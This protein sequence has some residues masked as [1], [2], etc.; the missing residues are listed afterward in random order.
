V[1]EVAGGP[2]TKKR[3]EAELAELRASQRLPWVEFPPAVVLARVAD[4]L[5]LHDRLETAPPAD[6]ARWQRLLTTPV[7]AAPEAGGSLPAPPAPVA[8]ADEPGDSSPSDP[9][10]LLGL[11]E[12]AGWFLDPERVQADAVALLEARSTR[13]IV[14]DQVKAERERAIVTGVVERELT[15]EVATRW[16]LRLVDMAAILEATG[17]PEA[18]AAARST[19]RS[20]VDPGQPP[21]ANPFGRRLAERALE[22]AI[23]VVSGRLSADAAGRRPDRAPDK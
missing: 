11:P 8:D 19:G 6:F 1:V 2:I 17:R 5:A 13:L 14:S 9:E 20:L 4:T 22:V 16:A 7:P 10:R 23:E 3:L 15:R 12:F 18:A 21:A